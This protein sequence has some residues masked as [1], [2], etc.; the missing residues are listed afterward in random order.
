[1]SLND[2]ASTQGR[3]GAGKFTPGNPGGPGNPYARQSA[4]LK[5]AVLEV[6]NEAEVRLIAQKLL[7]QALQGDVPSIKLAFAYAIGKP[8]DAVN[9]DEIDALEWEMRNRLSVSLEAVE[10]LTGRVP[11]RQ[12]NAVAEAVAQPVALQVGQ[13]IVRRLQ[14]R[15]ILPP[16]R[17]APA[18]TTAPPPGARTP[19]G[20]AS[21]RKGGGSPAFPPGQDRRPEV[22]PAHK[23]DA[24][25]YR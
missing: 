8:G 3:D 7:T 2:A 19:G 20:S 15:G 10:A 14:E 17:K 6:M 13:E 11:V 1:M 21:D 9:P 24:G 18:P 12:A 5:K 25:A 4:R 22:R 23:D 16:E